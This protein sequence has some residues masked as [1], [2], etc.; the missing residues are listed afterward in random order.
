MKIAARRWPTPVLC[1]AETTAG[2]RFCG[3]CGTPLDAA[4]PTA[5][6]RHGRLTGERR[7]LTVLFCDL[8]RSTEIAAQLDPEE[9][10]ELVGA[11]HRA[12][13]EAVTRYGGHVA[14][15]LGDGVM[16]YF[17][18]PEAHEN[19]AERA[20]RAGLA[21]VDAISHLEPAAHG[22]AVSRSSPIA[23]SG[24]APDFAAHGSRR[25]SI[26]E[27]LARL[28]VRVGIDSGAV[29]VGAGAG[30]DADV[31]GETPNIAARV[32]T[33]AAPDSVLITGATHRLLSGLFVVEECGA[34]ELK[35]VSNPV[36]LYRVLR[37]S[38][39]RGRLGAARG[40]TPFVGREE[41]LR[42]LLS[43]W[44]RAREG[45]GQLVL[46]AG[47]AGIGKSR[48]VSEFH[49][50]IG[51]TPHIWIESA[52]E[53][54][55]ENT[56]FHALSDMLSR[57]LQL[58][59]GSKADDQM[60]R[61]EKAL[62]SAGLKLERAAPL[63]ADLLQLPVG[64]RYPTTTLTSEQTR[65]QLLAALT[66]WVLGAAKR[67]PVV[68]VVEDLHWLD[69]S[70]LEFAKLLA[71]Q[72]AMA[73]L[74]LMCTARPEFHAQWPIRSHHTQIRL[75]PLSARNVREMITLVAAR[76]ELTS[77]SI[78]AVVERTG[79]VPLFVEELTRAV[80]ESGTIEP[81][82][83]QIPVTLQDSLLA[84]LDRLGSAKYVL[85]VGAVIGAEFSYKL[86]HAIDRGSEQKLENE[87]R[88]LT[89]ADLLYFRGIPPDASYQFKHGLIRDAAYEALLKSQ[90][91]EL[92]QL[93]AHTIDMQFPDLKQTHPELLARH[94]TEAGEIES[95]IAEW[96]RAGKAAEA[97]N[98]FKEAL[99]SYQR[100]VEL[101][102]RQTSPEGDHRELELNQ[103]VAQM[104]QMTKGW[105]ASETVEAVQR[106]GAVA[107]KNGSLRQ[108][109]NSLE[110]RGFTAFMAGELSIASGL[111][112]QSLDLALRDGG[113][114]LLA[115]VHLLQLMVHYSRG[116]FVGA[117]KYFATGLKFFDHPRFKESPIG[118]AI[119]AF[120][121]ANCSAW[122]LGHVDIARER[123][124]RMM[125]AVNKNN[126][127]DQAFAR[128]QG[129]ILLVSMREYE[130]AEDWVAA[131]L[132]LS[133]RNHFPSETAMARWLLGA[134]RAQLGRPTEGIELIRQGIAGLF[135]VRQRIGITHRTLCL[136][137]AQAQAGALVD[138]L[139]TIEQA[140]EANSEEMAY[141]P[142]ALRVRGELRLRHGRP[143]LAETDFRDSIAMAQS[144]GAKAWELRATMSLA[145]L[146]AEQGRRAEAHTTL[147]GIYDWFTEGFDTADLKEAKA[148]LGELSV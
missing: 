43:R 134:A 30:K 52:G 127:H 58:E 55:F 60:E 76:N 86:L 51:H 119:A 21:I 41:E 73:P 121:Y 118:A 34:Q 131:A 48:L 69:P 11:Y 136:A 129:A 50:R 2:K 110:T 137:K 79:G 38:G 54:F 92:H 132:L 88:K 122:A 36:E 57:W 95:A 39:A 63:I 128:I 123:L 100:A 142:E 104:L 83:R 141:R 17:G 93:I 24:Q 14:Q 124:A 4:A 13:A 29:V 116:D 82:A 77:G 5:E 81:S 105:I 7:H 135:E 59:A 90:R 85:Q 9:W 84:R 89:D 72:G 96:S 1:G 103:S 112:D 49:D 61:L 62:T 12:A 115:H 146:L 67:E 44:E 66:E 125:E 47:E 147:A 74:L 138:A 45:E 19:D 99:E 130:Q 6:P 33:A 80:L 68:I 148:L 144:M 20:A 109:A 3:E 56:P 16:G 28:S 31:F 46:V 108:L 23:S 113:P 97:R 64:E 106:V 75:S 71:E 117:E 126:P 53:Q 101:L 133:E 102:N 27:R 65:R 111:A 18:W 8:V 78:E 120:S 143:Q 32:Q 42:L 35:G 98:A 87:L 26:N 107:E 94:W 91:K 70:T 25:D 10:R 22:A 140:L 15:Y 145:R 114:A 139:A 40:L 37:P